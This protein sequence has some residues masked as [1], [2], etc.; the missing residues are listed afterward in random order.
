MAKFS[1]SD[2]TTQQKQYAAGG[3]VLLI[4]GGYF[5]WSLFWSPITGKINDNNKQTADVQQ[6]IEAARRQAKNLESLE[7]ELQALEYQARDAE[8]RLPPTRDLP[9]VFE[10]IAK[11]ARRYHVEMATFAPGG[12]STKTYFIEIPYQISISGN[13]HDIGKFLAAVAVEERIYN[14]SNVGISSVGDKLSVQFTLLAY[15]YKG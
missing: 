14:I 7:K 15:Q 1:F 13:Y 3:G 12:A 11:L 8:K 4:V 6:K 10:T 5:Y 2:L 9:T